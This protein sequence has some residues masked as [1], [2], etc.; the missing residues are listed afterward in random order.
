MKKRTNSSN[1]AIVL[2]AT[3]SV[4]YLAES[5][6]LLYIENYFAA[7]MWALLAFAASVIA[8]GWH[9]NKR[10][11]IWLGILIFIA[12]IIKTIFD[13]FVLNSMQVTT[14][15]MLFHLVSLIAA[16]SGV[17]VAAATLKKKQ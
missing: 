14:M 9:F 13:L 7:Q 17:I 4:F 8:L 16:V 2:L 5:S 12:R 1:I 11:F 10:L 6:A 15:T 3:I